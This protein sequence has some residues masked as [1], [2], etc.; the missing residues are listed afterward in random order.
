[1][2]KFVENNYSGT[3]LPS[4]YPNLLS[5]FMP[6]TVLTCWY[7]AKLPLYSTIINPSV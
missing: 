5:F 2:T 1:M 7:C 6:Y 4:S 3:S